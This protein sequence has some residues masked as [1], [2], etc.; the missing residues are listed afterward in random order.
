MLYGYGSPEAI[1]FFKSL[2]KQIAVKEE[3][4]SKVTKKNKKDTEETE[5]LDYCR[6]HK[7]DAKTARELKET[8]DVLDKVETLNLDNPIDLMLYNQYMTALDY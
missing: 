3:H 2:D 8:Q 5:I 7:L 6:E 1:E 4:K